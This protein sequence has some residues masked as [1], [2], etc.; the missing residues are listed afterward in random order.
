MGVWRVD[1]SHGLGEVLR[2]G[3]A[4]F[5]VLLLYQ[6]LAETDG[7]IASADLLRFRLTWYNLP[8]LC[9]QESKAT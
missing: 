6:T 2:M 9:S 8:K 5:L 3:A 7:G 1:V 4:S